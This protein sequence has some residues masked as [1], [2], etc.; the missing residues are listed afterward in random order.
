MNNHPRPNTLIILILLLTFTVLA[1]GLG[2]RITDPTPIP[3]EPAPEA[4]ATPIAEDANTPVSKESETTRT[5]DLPVN[6]MPIETVVQI[7]TLDKNNEP[8]W[9]GSGSIISSDGYILTNAH[10]VLSDKYF[11][12]YGLLVSLT[13]KDD[14]P[15][16]PTYLAETVVVDENLD[17]A[18]I[19]VTG[20]LDGNPIDYDTLNLPAISLGN[21]DETALGTPLRILGYP[22]IGGETITLTSG[23]VAGFTGEPGVKGRAYIKTSATIAGGNSGGAGIN[24]YGLLIGVPTQL[25][26]G[27]ENDIVDC[28]VLADTNQD[29]VIDEADACIP[30]GGFINALR[31]INLAKPLI[32]E[33]YNTEL[34]AGAQP[35]PAPERSPISLPDNPGEV[36]F[37]DD[38]EADQDNWGMVDG[39]TIEAGQ[40]RLLLGEP[41][42][43]IWST[44]GPNFDDIDYQVDTRKL[45]GPDDNSFGQVFRFQDEKNFY[46]FEI[47]SDGY[48]VVNKLEDGLWTALIDW[49]ASPLIDVGASDN[50][51]STIIQGN[52]FTFLINGVQVDSVVDDTFKD[53]GIGVIASSY[54]EPDVAVGFDNVLVRTPGGTRQIAVPSEP[55]SEGMPVVYEDDFSQPDTGWNLDSDSSVARNLDD[56][57]LSITVNDT[58]TDAW[59]THSTAL[60]DVV[61]EVD[62]HKVAG[63]DMNNYGIICRYR[64]S[65]NYYFLQYG[66]DGTYAVTRYLNGEA[67]MLVEWARTEAVKSG[68]AVNRLRGECVG[69]TISLYVNDTLLAGV[70]DD[71]LSYGKIALAV[72]TYDEG[73]VQVKFD[74][75]IVRSPEASGT[76]EG[77]TLFFD[78]FSDNSAVW[79]E[80]TSDEAQYSFVDGE[81]NINI[82][83]PEYLVWARTNNIWG[84]IRLNVDARQVSGPVDNEYG[85]VCRYQDADNFYQFGISGDGYYRLGRWLKGDFEE[86]ASWDKHSSINQGNGS[87][88][89]TVLCDG[90]QLSL[91]VND[92]FLFDLADDTLPVEGDV[93]LYVGT[94]EEGNV[95]I[96]FDNLEITNP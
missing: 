71:A 40:I 45:G 46:T 76:A 91:M 65:D 88:H 1:C 49:S 75:L 78:D 5:S 18:I 87:N 58:Q 86:L 21:S 15:P 26:Y 59:S 79:P 28:R 22:G 80:T 70:E 57:E 53:G 68:E 39:I 85:V 64:D 31:P 4:S 37:E 41:S 52:Y 32:T 77:G 69:S 96:A 84:S 16:T 67:S 73:G 62:A 66:S 48:Y 74:N 50:R 13:T 95:I 55:E 2:G 61:L 44:V 43:Y 38:F 72:G 14:E 8:L 19:R 10:V 90:N 34:V 54:A 27:G 7:W 82:V 83:A 60:R 33:A 6:S 20:D 89:M 51:L 9:S 17:L 11:T 47:S 3:V 93:A 23:E 35:E 24:E 25:G 36:L 12:V 56:G 94:F 92:T 81:Y 63:P 42:N 30:T 29:G